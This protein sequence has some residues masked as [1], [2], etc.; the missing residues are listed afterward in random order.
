MKRFRI[1]VRRWLPLLAVLALSAPLQLLPLEESSGGD[2]SVRFSLVGA[3]PAY[4]D[5]ADS[6]SAEPIDPL[7]DDPST[8]HP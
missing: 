8:P 5:S 4:A 1:P 3:V 7:Q 2:S 6:S